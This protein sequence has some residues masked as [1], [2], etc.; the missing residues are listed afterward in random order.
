MLLLVAMHIVSSGCYILQT[1]N[2]ETFYAVRNHDHL[3]A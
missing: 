2:L 3:F 1:L